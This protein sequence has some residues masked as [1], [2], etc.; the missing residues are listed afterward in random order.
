MSR[1]SRG[2][3]GP[4][5]RQG[6]GGGNTRPASPEPS[7]DV[8][9]ENRPGGAA[10]D[11]AIV[12]LESELAELRSL[13]A[14]KDQR[15]AELSRT[16]TSAA[17]L[18][19]DA[20]T[21]AAEL[22]KSRRQLGESAAEVQELRTLLLAA[23]GEGAAPPEGQ[24]E[25]RAAELRAHLAEM[26]EENR[27]LRDAL[28]A[29]PPSPP[30]LGAASLGASRAAAVPPPPPLAFPSEVSLPPAAGGSPGGG[31]IMGMPT[32]E[33]ASTTAVVYSTI[34]TEKHATIGPTTLQG[35]GTVDGVSSVAIVLLQRNRA[36]VY[37]S[38]NTG[39]SMVAPAGQ[40]QMM[41]QSRVE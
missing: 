1:H 23:R 16:D 31:Q 17:R 20:R 41:M 33:E 27:M 7:F 2:H 35:V 34:H 13:C 32:M 10:Q 24:D 22:R 28:A 38:Q 18:K 19:H 26:Q 29:R 8:A 40:L 12:A 3:S 4:L 39:R 6:W 36:S 5:P 25:A 11:E 21:L 37:T 9:K 14:R 30:Q 15:I